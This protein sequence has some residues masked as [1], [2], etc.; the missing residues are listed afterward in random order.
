VARLI[1]IGREESGASR[2]RTGD[3]LDAIQTLSQLSYGPLVLPQ[4]S[5]ELVVLRP[6]N[7][8]SLVVF[9][10]RKAQVQLP[11]GAERV[12]Q[13]VVAAL[14]IRAVRS[15]ASISS[16]GIDAPPQAFSCATVRI[17]AHQDHVTDASRPLALHPDELIAE[18]EDHV[19][20]SALSDGSIDL[21]PE[22]GCS[23]CDGRLRDRTFFLIRRQHRQRMLVV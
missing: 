8:E 19:E 17:R 1:S 3:L 13:N 12:E 10:G 2:A 11:S 5:R 23:M 9:R 14:I 7:A 18:K 20:P 15:S 16:G 4:C 22:L 6:R 21:D